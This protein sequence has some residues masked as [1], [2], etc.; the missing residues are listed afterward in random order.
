MAVPGMQPRM[1]MAAAEA[2]RPTVELSAEPLEIDAEVHATF[3][4]GT[5]T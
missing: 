3:V 2:G 1:L 4:V 5:A